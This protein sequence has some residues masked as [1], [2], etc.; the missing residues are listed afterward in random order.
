[1]LGPDSRLG[2]SSHGRLRFTRPPNYPH[3]QHPPWQAN[4]TCPR[5]PTLA[6]YPGLFVA[7]FIYSKLAELLD[8]FFLLIRKSPVIFLHW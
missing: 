8:T 1:V 4:P 5:S 6:G 7:L 2:L 3:L